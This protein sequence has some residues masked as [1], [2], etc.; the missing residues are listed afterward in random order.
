[1]LCRI[2]FPFPLLLL[3]L[4]LAAKG[5]ANKS[6]RACEPAL[7]QRALTRPRSRAPPQWVTDTSREK[8]ADNRKP[9]PSPPCPGILAAGGTGRDGLAWPQTNQPPTRPQGSG[10]G[11]EG[12]RGAGPKAPPQTG[13]PGQGRWR[14]AAR[15]SPF[16]LRPFQDELGGFNAGVLR[17]VGLRQTRKD[18]RGSA[19]PPGR[20]PWSD[21][22]R[23]PSFRYLLSMRPRPACGVCRG[24][25]SARALRPASR[26][27]RP[28]R[29]SLVSRRGPCT[30]NLRGKVKRDKFKTTFKSMSPRTFPF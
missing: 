11:G 15:S 2:L 17:H 26:A 29:R 10:E 16:L 13:R 22:L 5:D 24:C 21:K 19:P 20:K 25:A 3:V 4:L 1:M 14:R 6:G 9:L 18:T 23:R 8:G 27:T 12:S 7:P 28:D 30:Q